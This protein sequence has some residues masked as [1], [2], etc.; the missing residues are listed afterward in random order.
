MQIFTNARRL[1]L[2]MLSMVLS[3]GLTFAQER[4]VS[5]KVTADNQGLP[6]ANVFI[7]GTTV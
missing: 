5:G 7:Q 1:S 6:G 3:V 2:F 4:S